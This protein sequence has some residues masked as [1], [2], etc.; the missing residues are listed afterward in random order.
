MLLKVLHAMVYFSFTILVSDRRD[1]RE[2]LFQFNE[3]EHSKSL[4]QKYPFTSLK[5]FT[6]P[7]LF[8]KLLQYNRNLHNSALYFC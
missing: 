2:H 6:I 3:G 4:G 5:L 1:G 7:F 8:E